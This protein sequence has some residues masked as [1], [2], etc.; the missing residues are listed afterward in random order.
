MRVL[1]IFGTRPEAIK[2][3][4]VVR[5]LQND[6]GVTP[7]VCVTGQHRQMLDQVL[8]LFAI[9]ADY[10][11]NVMAQD[12]TLNGLAAKM[13][14]SLDEVL[15]HA[16]PDRVLV[17][18]DTTTAMAAAM[19]A[20]HRR[21]PVGHVEAGLRTYDLAK[22]WPEEMNRRAVDLVS[23][24]MFAPTVGSRANIRQE[25][26]GGQ[27]FVTGNTV[28]D[29]LK[30][31]AGLLDADHRLRGRIDAGLPAAVPG[32]RMILVTGHRRESFGDGFSN[33]CRALRRLAARDDVQ[34]VYPVHLNPNVRGPVLEALAGFD[35]V[36]LLLPQDYLPFVRLMQRADLVLTDSGGVQEE[37]P[38]LGKPVLVMRD[39]TERPEAVAAGAV[40]L[41]GSSC[42]NIVGQVELLLDDDDLRR[43]LSRRRN[44]YG[45][46]RAAA[47]IVD[48]VTGRPVNEFQAAGDA[49]NDLAA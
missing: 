1:S 32:R 30:S 2:M 17:H 25:K 16:R 27:V 10:D 9:R 29:A 49:A 35:N 22:P 34:I 33:I 7:L 43:G 48:A 24:L 11:L 42:D 20:F 46:G 12:Q 41:V 21:I 14:A 19:A 18:G 45:D 38:S 15:E 47:R 5:A 37:A 36:H 23:D 28:I 4:P 3:A 40:R 26:L 39:V 44:P 13:I 6:A 8:E 31:S